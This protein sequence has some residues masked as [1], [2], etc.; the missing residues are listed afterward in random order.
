MKATEKELNEVVESVS[1]N[2][3][4]FGGGKTG[5]GFNPI[6][7]ALA[8]APPQFA[9]GVDVN[10]VVQHVFGFVTAKE[11]H[12]SRMLECLVAAGFVDEKKIDEAR[13]LV[14]MLD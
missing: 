12:S 13:R 2:F 7:A 6:T 3:R 4:C 14:E 9:A 8:D 10:E 5:N 1:S 11:L